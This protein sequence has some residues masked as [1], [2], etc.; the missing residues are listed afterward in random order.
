LEGRQTLNLQADSG[1]MGSS[2]TGMRKLSM[3]GRQL[4]PL[5]GQQMGLQFSRTGIRRRLSQLLLLDGQQV[6]LQFSRTGIKKTR[7]IDPGSSNGEEQKY[8]TRDDR[9]RE[10]QQAVP[11]ATFLSLVLQN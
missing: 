2:Q 8:G 1:T 10:T 3:R 9:R 6:G 7:M 5:D 4:L 11:P